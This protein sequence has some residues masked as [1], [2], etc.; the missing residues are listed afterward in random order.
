MTTRAKAP[1]APQCGPFLADPDTPGDP[2][3]G[4]GVCATCH[5]LGQPGDVHHALPDVP[6]QAEVRARYDHDSDDEITE[7]NGGGS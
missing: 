6:E 5:R 7:R 4:L 1:P 2:Y 3:T